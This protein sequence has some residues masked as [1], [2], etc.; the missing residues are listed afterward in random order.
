M[1][2]IT[3]EGSSVAGWSDNKDSSIDFIP[4]L[5][6]DT[7]NAPR[8]LEESV[9]EEPVNKAN[10]ARLERSIKDPAWLI[11]F[12]EFLREQRC[13]YDLSFWLDVEDFK[14]EF[15]V[16]QIAAVASKTPE[17]LPPIEGTS[18]TPLEPLLEPER[19]HEVLGNRPFLIYNTYL[20]PSSNCQLS[21]NIGTD[22]KEE[23][24]RA[25]EHC[26]EHLTSQI[27]ITESS[28]PGATG[29]TALDIDQLAIIVW[30]YE[31]VQNRVFCVLADDYIPRVSAHRNNHLGYVYPLIFIHSL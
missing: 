8:V 11:L 27:L 4:D 25:L 17:N 15:E 31:R 12:R 18:S 19:P 20:V 7:H 16:A 30:L 9:R 21:F 2:A 10:A 24:Q 1:Y 3:V 6:L 14:T 28:D 29:S 22:L 26:V 13:E 5:A 23:L